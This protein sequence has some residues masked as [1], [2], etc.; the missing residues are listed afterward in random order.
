[1]YRDVVQ[2]SKIRHRILV[3]GRSI[4]RVALC[5]RVAGVLLVRIAVGML[6]GDPSVRF[7]V[8]APERGRLEEAF[9]AE[10]VISFFLMSLVLFASNSAKVAPFTGLLSGALIASYITFE[11]PISGMSIVRVALYDLRDRTNA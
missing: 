6:A 2:W 9:V 5:H 1:M 7:A 4:R 3:Q 8:T 10:A 11:A